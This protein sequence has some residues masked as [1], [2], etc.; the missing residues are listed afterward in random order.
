MVV[1]AS[2]IENAGKIWQGRRNDLGYNEFVH[3]HELLNCTQECVVMCVVCSTSVA[4][5]SF[6]GHATV[7]RTW[8]SVRYA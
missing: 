5:V 6:D 8:A 3:E 4:T 2:R 7:A 1:P